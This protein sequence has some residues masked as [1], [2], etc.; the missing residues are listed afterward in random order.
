MLLATVAVH[1][2][3]LYP[4]IHPSIHPSIEIMLELDRFGFKRKADTVFIGFGS[5]AEGGN[6][7]VV[8]PLGW[9][10]YDGS[11]CNGLLASYPAGRAGVCRFTAVCT[12]T[13]M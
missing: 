6:G 5:R 9:P 4:S 1:S 2:Y 11:L 8:V 7:V 13:S 12:G 10:W 3:T